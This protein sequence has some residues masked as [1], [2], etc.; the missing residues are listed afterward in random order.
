MQLFTQALVYQPGIDDDR[1]GYIWGCTLYTQHK[2]TQPIQPMVS[3]D[4][5]NSL[6]Q[7]NATD[8]FTH[9]RKENLLICDAFSKYPFIYR[10]SR[11]TAHSLSQK[12]QVLISQ[13]GPTKSLFTDNGAPFS[14]KELSQYLQ[15]QQISHIMSSPHYLPLNG[16]ASQNHKDCPQ[17]DPS[18]QNLLDT[19][20][21]NLQ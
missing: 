18:H 6:W 13:Y 7:D 16:K 9:K 21:L 8:Y 15:E 2:M 11:K 20:L 3:Q 12:L 5:P 10:V 19:F 17:H 14:S 1:A 4:V